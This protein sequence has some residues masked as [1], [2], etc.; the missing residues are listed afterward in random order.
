MATES[1]TLEGV[2]LPPQAEVD[3]VQVTGSTTTSS[4]LLHILHLDLLRKDRIIS[5]G[6]DP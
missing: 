5:V 2:Y 1:V 3:G 6:R 4:F